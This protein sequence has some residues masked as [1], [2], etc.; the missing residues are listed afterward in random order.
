MKKVLLILLLLPS[1]A[2]AQQRGLNVA[3]RPEAAR[4]NQRIAL[5]IGNSKYAESPLL[6]PAND[7]RDMATL[8]KEYGFDVLHGENMTQ[9]EMKTLI[10]SFGDKLRDGGTGLFYFA[11]HGVQVADHNYLIPVG[12]SIQSEA[13]IEYEAVDVGFVL[14]QMQEAQNPLNI[15]ILDACR[16]DPFARSSRS[17]VRGL[18]TVNAPVGTLIAY[19]TA[20]GN[21]AADGDGRNGLY[22]EELM[23]QMK[24]PGIRLLDVF[25]HTRTA[26]RQRTKG[27]QIPWESISIEG[28]FVLNGVTASTTAAWTT[29]T[30]APAVETGEQAF[31]RAIETSSLQEDFE[32]Y[33]KKFGERGLYADAARARLRHL[34]GK[35]AA[36]A[37]VTTPAK[38]LATAAFE[39]ETATTNVTGTT[40]EKHRTSAQQ[41]I[42]DLGNSVQI[43]MVKVPLGSF[44]MGT[45]EE[46]VAPVIPEHERYFGKTD[47]AA[48]V[49]WQTPQHVVTLPSFYLGK[50]EVTQAQWRAVAALPKVQRELVPDPSKFKGDQKPVE[51]ISW[52]D[53]QEFCARLSRATG[54]NYRLPS[55]AEWEYAAR[56]NTTTDFAFGAALPPELANYDG[57]T[58]Y[59]K[60]EKGVSRGQTVLVGSLGIANAF[61]LYDMHGNVFEWCQD[62]WHESYAGAPVD[63]SAWESGGDSNRRVARG[64]AWMTYGAACRSA[65]RVRNLPDFRMFFI[66]FRVAMDAPQK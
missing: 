7:A 24:Q 37:A 40:I 55:E 48:S 51:M 12:A 14:A 64:G 23:K 15:L 31:W 29:P 33:L 11:G 10:R 57:N 43:E 61:G 27:Q 66:G 45:A 26:V 5:V 56:A 49:R 35:P 3:A 47:A 50:F 38:T 25:L 65:L 2:L 54:R 9:K 28:D 39:F 63:G 58:P 60:G 30:A 8:L 4:P 1:L 34:R 52:E 16:N 36:N 44:R 17:A 42:E 62:V 41:Y 21:V 19:S 13:E 46:D 59:G 20:P 18:A 6:N 32:E 53:A 22:T